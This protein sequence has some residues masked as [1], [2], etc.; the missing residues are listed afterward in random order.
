MV[1]MEDFTDRLDEG[2]LKD[3]RDQNWLPN[4]CSLLLQ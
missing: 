4:F 2:A 1:G 3:N